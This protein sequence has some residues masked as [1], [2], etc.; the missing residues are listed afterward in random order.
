MLLV[1]APLHDIALHWLHMAEFSSCL[2]KCLLSTM[3]PRG[4]KSELSQREWRKCTATQ[5][6]RKTGK[7]CAGRE[8]R[9]LLRRINNV[10]GVQFQ[11]NWSVGT[12]SESEPVLDSHPWSDCYLS[13]KIRKEML[14]S[15]DVTAAVMSATFLRSKTPF[16]RH[17]YTLWILCKCKLI[18]H[19]SHLKPRYRQ[20]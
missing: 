16:W 6:F 7:P 1:F 3:L 8:M 10:G 19:L 14:Y 2:V 4:W 18:S 17:L 20:L 9:E 15:S 13:T 5:N 11:C 12:G